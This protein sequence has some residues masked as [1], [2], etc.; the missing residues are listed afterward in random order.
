MMITMA[1][2][3][4]GKEKKRKTDT[5]KDARIGVVMMGWATA[6]GIEAKTNGG[7]ER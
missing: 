7:I 1:V 3:T 5:T 4:I 6:S 2:K